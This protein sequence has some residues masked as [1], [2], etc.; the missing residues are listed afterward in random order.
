MTQPR[1]QVHGEIHD[2]GERL[3]LFGVGNIVEAIGR[4]HLLTPH[5]TE[6]TPRG[7]LQVKLRWPVVCQLAGELGAGWVPGP[8]LQAWIYEQVLRRTVLPPLLAR[9]TPGEPDPRTYQVAGAQLIAAGLSALVFDDPGTGKTLTTLLGLMELRERGRLPLAAPMLV[10]CPTSVVDSWVRDARRWTPFSVAAWRGD[11]GARRRLVDSRHDLYIAGYGVV[12][13]DVDVTKTGAPL[14]AKGFAAVAIDECHLIKSP[15]SARS[16]AVVKLAN[17]AQTVI[18]LSGTPITHH[19]GDLH[20]ALKAMDPVSWP[21]SERYTARYLDSVQGDYSD[22]VLGLN[23]FR[24]PE[25]RLCLTGQYRRLAKE[26]VLSELP[27]KVRSERIVTLPPAARRAYDEMADVM[28]AQLDDGTELPAFEALAQLQRLLQL[29]CSSCDVSITHG[30]DVDEL[31]IP[32]I[33]VHATPREPSWKI[34]ELIDVL[35]ERPGRST[36]VFAPSA[37]LTRLAGERAAK[38][39]YRVGYVI[40]GQSASDR[41]GQVEAFQNGDLNVMCATT[42]AGGVG[43]TLTAA[44][45]VA[46]LQRPWSFVEASQAEDR[47]HRIG[48]EIHESIEI[49]DIIAKDTVDAQVRAVLAGKAS[50]LAELLADPRV[51]RRCLGA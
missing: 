51:A 27:P 8:K 49:V 29:A 14:L 20:Q 43:L 44:S 19:S 13:N 32:K 42:G 5:F 6:T 21:S 9:T 45:T 35:D 24:E 50:A 34:D 2:D 7:G 15:K 40:G 31:G 12:G 36:L 30:P 46:F 23:R 48:S 11:A 28:L 4:L 10:V 18:P 37:G 38:E 16:K 17:R 41:T 22:D 3:I 26:D 39:G 33:H 47:A 25:F 1:Y